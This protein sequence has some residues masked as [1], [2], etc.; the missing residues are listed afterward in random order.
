MQAIQ[1]NSVRPS[2]LRILPIMVER[3]AL[4]DQG[5]RT[6]CCPTTGEARNRGLRRRTSSESQRPALGT[7]SDDVGSVGTVTVA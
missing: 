6:V 2:K 4:F 3:N 1:N 5:S 7:K